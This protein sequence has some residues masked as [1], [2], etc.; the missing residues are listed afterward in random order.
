[1]GGRFG[2]YG[3]TKRKQWL[4]KTRLRP[5]ALR[6]PGKNKPSKGSRKSGSGFKTPFLAG[7]SIL[8]RSKVAS[9]KLENSG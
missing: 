9:L 3:D 2:K 6:Q 7:S 5:P 1:M 8:R 4:R